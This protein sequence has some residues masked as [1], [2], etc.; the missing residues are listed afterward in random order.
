M[1]NRVAKTEGKTGQ[2]LPPTSTRG[3]AARPW[4][5]GAPTSSFY[6]TKGQLSKTKEEASTCL[7]PPAACLPAS[8]GLGRGGAKRRD[9]RVQ[10]G[11]A[12]PVSPGRDKNAAETTWLSQ[13]EGS[14]GQR[15]SPRKTCGTE[16]GALLR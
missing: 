11:Q 1:G 5:S 4:S 8:R 16:P 9:R 6:H 7:A 12:W 13:A 10:A 2:C 14:A 15:E 3:R